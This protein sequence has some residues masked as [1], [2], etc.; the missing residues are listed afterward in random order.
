MRQRTPGSRSPAAPAAPS[1]RKRYGQHF[2][3][4]PRILGRIAD[5]VGISP[6]DTVVEIGPG[7]GALTAELLSRVG[8]KGRLVAVEVDRD[9]AA[10]LKVQYADHRE[11][12]LVEG[13]VLATDLTVQV[14]RPF[15]LAGNI[16][17]NITTPILFR[18]LEPPRAERMVFLVQLE[19]AQRLVAAPA[20]E[21]YSALSVNA[22]AL[23]KLE[24]VFRVPPGAF[25]P[26]P[27]VESAV[28]RMTPRESPDIAPHEEPAFKKLVQ[29]LFSQRRKQM[30]RAVRSARGLD[31][32][33]AG[34]ALDRAGIGHTLRPEVLAPA[35]FARLLRAL[36]QPLADTS[37]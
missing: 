34:A 22:Q 35:D 18:A 11:F 14:K 26:P 29:A 23:A 31:A 24:I 16:P 12:T 28:I 36:T 3:T 32:Y 4:D 7:R 17:Y 15:L 30:L 9:L 8:P 1:A 33:N 20:S 19:V 5:A 6:G 21:D 25:N 13:D 10:M 37:A 27:K 2:L